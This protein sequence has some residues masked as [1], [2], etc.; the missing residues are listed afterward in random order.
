M[1]I[2]IFSQSRCSHCGGS[3]PTEKCFK[4]QKNLKEYKKPPFTIRNS[5][6]KCNEHNGQDTKYIYQIWIGGSFS[7]KL[8]ETGLFG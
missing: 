3:H 1:T 8:S 2:D 6:N 4:Q 5:N 7:C